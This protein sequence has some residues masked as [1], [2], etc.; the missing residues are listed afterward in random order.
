MLH[1]QIRFA[2]EVNSAV[3]VP[4]ALLTNMTSSLVAARSELNKTLAED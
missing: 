2:S 3:S 1:A 4:L